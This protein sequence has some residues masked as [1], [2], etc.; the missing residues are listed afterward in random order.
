MVGTLLVEAAKEVGRSCYF[1][2]G[3]VVLIMVEPVVV[4]TTNLVD[5]VEGL[6][7]VALG[8]QSVGVEADFGMFVDSVDS[9]VE[10][11]KTV[12]GDFAAEI[13]RL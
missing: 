9:V 10:C 11:Q 2:V 5:F 4:A 8:L 7:A 13:G 6:G 12:V 1:V 3:S